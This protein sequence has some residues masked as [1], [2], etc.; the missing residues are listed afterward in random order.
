MFP[1]WKYFY[2]FPSWKTF[3]NYSL[4]LEGIVN[5]NFASL[6]FSSLENV[7]SLPHWDDFS[8]L[9]SLETFPPWN[10]QKTVASTKFNVKCFLQA[11]CFHQ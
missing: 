4:V 6:D 2:L 10:I 1:P 11:Q 3:N 5:H 9:S 8:N 7:F